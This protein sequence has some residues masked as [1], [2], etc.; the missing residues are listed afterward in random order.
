[1]D[2]YNISKDKVKICLTEDEVLT[3]FG[4]Y[5]NID[6]ECPRARAVLDSLLMRALPASMLPLDCKRVLIEVTEEASGCS[7]Q[8]TRLYDKGKRLHKTS[9]RRKYILLFKC[10]EDMIKFIEQTPP[11]TLEL[12][13]SVK[14]IKYSGKFGLMFTA[15]DIQ[16]KKITAFAEYGKLIESN[17]LLGAVVLEYGNIICEKATERLSAAFGK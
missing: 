17:S 5:D 7:I 15:N 1:M 16:R 4:G 2:T 3:L 10:S 6:Y 13:C 9:G 12:L 11:E 14:L 8:I